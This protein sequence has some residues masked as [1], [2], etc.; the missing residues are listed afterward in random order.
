MI[1][2]STIDDGNT[3]RNGAVINGA[4]NLLLYGSTVYANS[5][6]AAIRLE[7]NQ[8]ALLLNNVILNRQTDKPSLLQNNSFSFSS[9]SGYNV[10][11]TVFAASGV[12]LSYG[13]YTGDQKSKTAADLGSWAWN[14]TNRVYTWNG[15]VVDTPVETPAINY[16]DKT[17]NIS[18]AFDE[19]FMFDYSQNDNN[20][21]NVTQNNIG[22]KL[23]DNWGS[24]TYY[25][26]QLNTE[27]NYNGHYPGAYTKK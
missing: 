7:G 10:M 8:M 2:R 5:T 12:S 3:S 15:L 4:P 27:R 6:S 17:D 14:G 21:F 18:K 1:A 16:T 9:K 19:G 26:D 25:K 23:R 22:Q 20:K 13:S 24:G 11:G